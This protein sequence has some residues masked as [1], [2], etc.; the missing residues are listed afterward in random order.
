MK[1]NTTINSYQGSYVLKQGHYDYQYILSSEKREN[2]I[3]GNKRETNNIYE[4]FV[5]YRSQ[6]LAADI[7]IGYTNFEF[8]LN[9]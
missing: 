9:R 3:E 4:I 8:S 7:L 6:Q 2:E 5:Y 1:Y